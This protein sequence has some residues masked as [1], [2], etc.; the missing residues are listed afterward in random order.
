M[1]T[2]PNPDGSE[3]RKAN[4][5][6]TSN[7]ISPDQLRT[8]LQ[9]LTSKAF[10]SPAC[11]WC[12]THHWGIEQHVVAASLVTTNNSIALSQGVPAVILT[13]NNCGLILPF[14]A[15][16]VGAVSQQENTAADGHHVAP[17]T[18]QCESPEN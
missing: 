9:W 13:C 16:K 14:N 18:P 5:P 4:T 6:A 1:D 11:P 7:A 17:D 10:Q 8:A 15:I 3:P 2:S 12:N